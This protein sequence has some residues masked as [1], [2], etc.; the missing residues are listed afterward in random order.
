M[1]KNID[2]EQFSQDLKVLKRI[3]YDVKKSMFERLDVSR[4]EN[5]SSRMLE[6]LFN[7]HEEHGIGNL[8]I[9]ALLEEA[10]IKFERQPVTLECL[11]EVHTTSEKFDNKGFIDIVVHLKEYTLIIENKISH[12]LNNPFELYQQYVKTTYNKKNG[13]S[14]NN[15]FIIMGINKPK[16][17]P[18]NFIFVSHAQ[19]CEN[20]KIKLLNNVSS[21]EK[22]KSYYF[23]QDYIEAIEHMSNTKLNE[24]KEEFF[25]FIAEHYQQLDQIQE[26]QKYMFDIANEYLEKILVHTQ[27]KEKYFVHNKSEKN[28]LKE[29]AYKGCYMYSSTIKKVFNGSEIYV[30]LNV[31]AQGI[32]LSIAMHDNRRKKYYVQ[33]D[34]IECLKGSRLISSS[35]K[36]DQIFANEAILMK[37][38]YTEF[39]PLVIAK[40]IDSYVDKIEN[41]SLKMINS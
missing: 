8:A 37:W 41:I 1:E 39:D 25:R 4:Y 3:S 38:N 12:I 15:V 18:K 6:F 26:Q 40:K 17:I 32:F 10:N 24:D 31:I 9:V 5:V 13:Y 2:L 36:V 16:N 28:N 20:L 19:F 7:S 27:C 35:E 33:E 14:G 30:I 23:I 22:S 29:W 34:I 11:S 21:Q